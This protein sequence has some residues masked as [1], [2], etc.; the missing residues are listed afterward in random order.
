MSISELFQSVRIVTLVAIV[1][2]ILSFLVSD[3]NAQSPSLTANTSRSQITVIPGQMVSLTVVPKGNLGSSY[4]QGYWLPRGVSLFSSTRVLVGD[5]EVHQVSFF[6]SETM[7]SGNNDVTLQVF[8]DVGQVFQTTVKVVVAKSFPKSIDRL[9]RHFTSTV[10]LYA[11]PSTDGT[12]QAIA[13]FRTQKSVEVVADFYK[14]FF[15]NPD[16][17]WAIAPETEVRDTFAYIKASRGRMILQVK[18]KDEPI[19][20]ERIVIV[21]LQRK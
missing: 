2:I 17:P 5:N 3:A 6:V 14:Q 15:Q 21:T 16:Y 8:D 12:V 19:N 13:N 1:L 4:V 11:A 20:H 7:A 18:V 10:A 9:A